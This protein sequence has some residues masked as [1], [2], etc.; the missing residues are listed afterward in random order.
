M[1][2]FLYFFFCLFGLLAAQTAAEL[3]FGCFLFMWNTDTWRPSSFCQG[4][5]SCSIIICRVKGHL[6]A[7]NNQL[8]VNQLVLKGRWIT[9]HTF[10]IYSHQSTFCLCLSLVSCLPFLLSSCL[11]FFHSFYLCLL[12]FL[13]QKFNFLFCFL[14]KFYSVFVIHTQLLK[15]F[16]VL[17]K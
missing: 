3:V 5:I 16:N 10:M 9:T 11:F 8:N 2:P 15:I 4:N 14:K 1:P 17:L 7:W 6:F 12:F 13:C